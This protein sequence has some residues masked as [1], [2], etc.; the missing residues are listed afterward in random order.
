MSSRTSDPTPT[1]LHYINSWELAY[2]CL[3]NHSLFCDLK[4]FILEPLINRSC[5]ILNQLF[6][7]SL[8]LF[9]YSFWCRPFF[10]YLILIFLIAGS[11]SY[12]SHRWD[13]HAIQRFDNYLFDLYIVFIVYLQVLQCYEFATKKSRQHHLGNQSS[14]CDQL[15]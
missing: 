3:L 2:I 1:G 11:S 7:E 10:L 9:F 12:R 14:L 4:Q 5:L 15:L 8:M 6:Q 13:Q